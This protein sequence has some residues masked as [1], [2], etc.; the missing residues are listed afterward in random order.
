MQRG[1]IIHAER[2]S[3]PDVWE[4]RWREPGPDGRRKHRRMVIGRIDQLV[5]ES[6]ARER[7][8]GLH[9]DINFWDARLKGKPLTIAELADHYRQRELKPD[10]VWKT[11]STKLTYEGYLSKWILP[12]WGNYLLTR[13]NA[14]EVELWLRSLPL[15]RS[16]CAKARNLM[17][18]LFNHG[19]RHDICSRNPIR[20]VRQSS[21]RRK[22]PA[23]LSV[24]DIQKLLPAL[25]FRERTLVL[26][27]V[28][29]GLR[30][31]EL[32][33]LKWRDVNFRTRE[34]SV[35][36]SIVFQVVG[37]CKTEASQK[38]IPLDSYL[39]KALRE[40]RKHTKYRAPDDWVFASPA[41]HGR[42]P[43][44]G[45]SI[46]RNLIRPAAVE[47]GITQ[48]IGWHTFRHTYSSL[49]RATGADIKVMQELLRHASS[50]V[51]L[52]TYTQAVT[53]HKRRAQSDVVRLFRTSTSRTG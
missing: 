30:M 44:W 7:I 27:D 23:V 32:L 21:K 8:A 16:S 6:G 26:L 10:T 51:T 14:G 41:S 37:P 20:L 52:D 3:G 19:I 25:P 2:R 4:F 47:L 48:R 18:V 45:Q 17:S 9:L 53:L 22:I 11:Y 35:T 38:P 49:L 28:G 5:D 46:M 43:Y 50:R 40:W 1:S 31:S 39:A 29:T 36:R 42:R 13:I 33:A 15:A 24:A 12:R 34:I